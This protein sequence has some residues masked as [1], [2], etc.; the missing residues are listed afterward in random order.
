[1][2]KSRDMSRINSSWAYEYIAFLYFIACIIP[3]LMHHKRK[4]LVVFHDIWPIETY[5][6]MMLTEHEGYSN[7]AVMML[8]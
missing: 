7:V 4:V 5:D 6:T 8:Y 2:R 3:L 1:M